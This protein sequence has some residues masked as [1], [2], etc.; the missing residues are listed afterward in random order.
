MVNLVRFVPQATLKQFEDTI[1]ESLSRHRT[2]HSQMHE[3]LDRIHTILPHCRPI[4]LI[5]NDHDD[6][7]GLVVH[8]AD[9]DVEC[10]RAK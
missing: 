9:Q 2:P 8:L 7:S 10:L 4:Q 1:A 6:V 3:K 5:Q